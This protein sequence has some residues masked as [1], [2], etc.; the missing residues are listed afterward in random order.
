MDFQYIRAPY[1]RRNV[2]CFFWLGLGLEP[3]YETKAGTIVT[4]GPY[5][6]Q[7]PHDHSKGVGLVGGSQPCTRLSTL[8]VPFFLAA[9]QRRDDTLGTLQVYIYIFVTRKPSRGVDKIHSNNSCAL[10]LIIRTFSGCGSG[11]LSEQIPPEDVI[12]RRTRLLVAVQGMASVT[13][14]IPPSERGRDAVADRRRKHTLTRLATY[15]L[16]GSL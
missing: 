7:P 5:V 9:S 14:S 8:W 6:Y 4:P 11:S 15:R 12:A 16:P 13:H 2:R 1:V 10:C 3:T